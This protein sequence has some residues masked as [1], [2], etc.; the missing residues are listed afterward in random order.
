MV[1]Y[2]TNRLHARDAANPLAAYH[3]AHLP[4]HMAHSD[5][6]LQALL[7]SVA[8][9]RF[10]SWR[11]GSQY[12]PAAHLGGIAYLFVRGMVGPNT[13]QHGSEV[14]GV[15]AWRPPA[16]TIVAL[17]HLFAGEAAR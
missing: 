4:Q 3:P 8:L 2:K 9:H 1:D 10:L 7:Y 5:Y 6:P 16:A 11:L 17:H 12:D 13:P 14:T 15:F